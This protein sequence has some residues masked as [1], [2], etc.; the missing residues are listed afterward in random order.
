MDGNN[1]YQPFQKHT[2]RWGLNLKAGLKLL[3]SKD[4]PTP[5][6]QSTEIINKEKPH[7]EAQEDEMLCREKGHMKKQQGSR[8]V[9]EEAVSDTA[10]QLSIQTASPCHRLTTRQS[11]SVAQAGVQWHNLSSLQPLPPRLKKFSCLSLPKTG[12]LHVGQVGL[13]LLTSSDS[14]ASPSPSAEITGFHHVAQTGLEL[15]SSSD[16]PTSAFQNSRITE[17]L[18]LLSRLECSGVIL[19]HYSPHLPCPS[20]SPTS[21]SQRLGFNMLARLILNYWLQ[22]IR[23]PRLPKVLGLQARS[24]TDVRFG[25]S[26]STNHIGEEDG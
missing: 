16:L 13:K 26:E 1:E 12:F 3:S 10:L 23:L 8:P 19:T 6:S 22:V 7:E 5:T 4:P 15:M 17:S 20:K 24:R 25:S 11:H 18:A 9:G 21:A 14:A 2:K